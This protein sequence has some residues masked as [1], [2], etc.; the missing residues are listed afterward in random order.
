MAWYIVGTSPAGPSPTR[1]GQTY[2]VSGNRLTLGTRGGWAAPRLRSCPTT[3]C[4]AGG[5]FGSGPET[6]RPC[7]RAAPSAAV[8]TRLFRPG[9]RQIPM[10]FGGFTLCRRG[11]GRP[12]GLRAT[13]A[14]AGSAAGR[15]ELRAGRS[16][17]WPRELPRLVTM[18]YFALGGPDGGGP[19][20]AIKRLDGRG[21]RGRRL[22]R[23]SAGRGR[24]R[25][26]RRL[27]RCHRR[28]RVIFNPATDDVG[29]VGRSPRSL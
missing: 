18:P 10:R 7:G 3:A 27:L 17:R 14:S 24:G 19:S 20:S 13:S 29:D 9:R 2:G 28:G 26:V 1:S 22:P 25:G 11:R 6:F 5:R 16:G 15:A 23:R 4:S 12:A 8:R 21:D